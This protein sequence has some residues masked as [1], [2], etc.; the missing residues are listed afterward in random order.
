MT[1]TI[2][3]IARLVHRQT[4]V[5]CNGTFISPLDPADALIRANE[6][7]GSTHHVRTVYPEDHRWRI[8][9]HEKLAAAMMT[10]EGR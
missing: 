3:F 4:G 10:P 8:G 9:W 1:P 6:Q 2:T 7:F 5:T